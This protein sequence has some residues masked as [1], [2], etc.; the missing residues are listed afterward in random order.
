MA[1]LS[2]FISDAAGDDA[3]AGK[4]TRKMAEGPTLEGL[5]AFFQSEGYAD[6][7]D[8]DCEKIM[9]FKNELLPNRDY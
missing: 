5:K 6:V 9:N 7:S 1:D 4:L 2:D 3:L 8:G